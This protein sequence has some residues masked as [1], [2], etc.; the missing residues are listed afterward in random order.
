MAV[1][2]QRQMTTLVL[3]T[4]VWALALIASAFLFKGSPVKDWLQAAL[5]IGGMV[6]LL[7]QYPRLARDRRC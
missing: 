4:T 7:W 1:T 5:F 3:W 2:S 6:L